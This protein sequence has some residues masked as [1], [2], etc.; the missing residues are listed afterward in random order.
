MS[1]ACSTNAAKRNAYRILV[2][3]PGEEGS[4]GRPRFWWVDNIKMEAV[5]AWQ[6][7]ATVW[8][9]VPSVLFPPPRVIYEGLVGQ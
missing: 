7:H 6:E 9:A 2:G 8:R 5:V 3:T 4:L 1:R